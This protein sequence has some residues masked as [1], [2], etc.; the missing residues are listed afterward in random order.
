MTYYTHPWR[1]VRTTDGEKF[2]ASANGVKSLVF[3]GEE[4]GAM[5]DSILLVS[6]NKNGNTIY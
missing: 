5:P 1:F 4:F 6:I 2:K 3:E